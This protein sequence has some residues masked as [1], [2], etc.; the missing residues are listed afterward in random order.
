MVKRCLSLVC[1]AFLWQ[2]C[3]STPGLAQAQSPPPPAWLVLYY[4]SADCDLEAHMMDDQQELASVGSTEQVQLLALVDRSPLNSDHSGYS[5]EQVRNLKPWTGARLLHF[6]PERIESLQDWGKISMADGKTFERFLREGVRRYPG[7]RT[8]VILSGHGVGPY[9]MA[10]DDS[11][12]EDDLLTPQEIAAGFRATG[13]RAELLG[14]DACLMSHLEV[15]RQLAACARVL[16]ASQESEPESGWDYASLMH[17]LQSR[18]DMSALHLG[19]AVSRTYQRSFDR[20]IDSSV[21]EEGRTI[22]LSVVQ[23]DRLQP[24]QDALD[25]VARICLA[26]DSARS[27]LLQALQRTH[28][29]GISDPREEGEVA[30]YDCQQLASQLQSVPR[31]RDAAAR[32]DL[33]CRNAVAMKVQGR[34]QSLSGGLSVS[35]EENLDATT[36]W[37]RLGEKLVPP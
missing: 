24:V 27:Q 26:E 19:G 22:T 7:R 5:D 20:N 2:G 4:G 16:V 31:L 37:A 28:H 12:P 15:A 13:L 29:F 32:L 6:T 21:Q 36:A 11:A 14:L 25:E 23:L 3:A 18:P 33:A 35:L 17:S 1:L 8:V 34:D 9:G 10:Q 30:Y